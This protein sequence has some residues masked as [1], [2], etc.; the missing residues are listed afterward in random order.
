[1]LKANETALVLRALDSASAG[2]GP[3]HS[4]SALLTP[5]EARQLVDTARSLAHQG[6]ILQ[7]QHVSLLK[8]GVFSI[9]LK[10]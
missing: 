8:H 6:E 10:I 4:V 7:S 5:H 2:H 9:I 3:V 1:M